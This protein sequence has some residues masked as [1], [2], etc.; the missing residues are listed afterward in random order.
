MLLPGAG[1]DVLRFSALHAVA[2]TFQLQLPV[3]ALHAQRAAAVVGLRPVTDTAASTGIGCDT[4]TPEQ[5]HPGIIAAA[6]V[7]PILQWFGQRPQCGGGCVLTLG[8][9][10]CLPL[11]LLESAL[12]CTAVDA[13][14]LPE[15]AQWMGRRLRRLAAGRCSRNARVWLGVGRP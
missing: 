10:G 2:G 6:T 4:M 13:R 5:F 1:W 15:H 14:A 7:T 11:Q 12:L 3:N 8:S 9:G